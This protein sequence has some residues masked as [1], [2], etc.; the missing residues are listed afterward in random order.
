MPEGTF[1]RKWTMFRVEISEVDQRSKKT[2]GEET[3]E[4]VADKG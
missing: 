2:L 1:G 4:V 3:L